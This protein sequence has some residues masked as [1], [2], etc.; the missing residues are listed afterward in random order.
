MVTM[1]RPVGPKE[2]ELIVDLQMKAFP[3]RL[4]WQPI[5]YP[6]LNFKYAA[7]I[8]ERWNLGTDSKEAGFVTAFD[9]PD[10]YFNKFQIQT[11]GMPHHQEFWVPANEL[12]EFNSKIIGEIRVEKSFIGNLFQAS[13]KIK[14]FI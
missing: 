6:V 9:I 5:F 14:K 13:E 2:L 10:E 1:Y 8:A 12:V 7:E 4:Y 3:P 11:V